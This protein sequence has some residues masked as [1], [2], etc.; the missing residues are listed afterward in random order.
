MCHYLRICIK[1]LVLYPAILLER[2]WLRHCCRPSSHTLKNFLSKRP[3]TSTG[4]RRRR[5]V[6]KDLIS[7]H[8]S[9]MEANLATSAG[10]SDEEV[11]PPPLDLD[12]PRGGDGGGGGGGG[13]AED[14]TTEA[15]LLH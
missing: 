15:Y 5:Q 6:R 4:G 3:R 2:F 9:A 1:N 7:H 8:V 14:E 13:G 11:V 12:G 10:F